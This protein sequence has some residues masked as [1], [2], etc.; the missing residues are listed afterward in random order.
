MGAAKTGTGLN[1]KDGREGRTQ[2]SINWQE[3]LGEAYSEDLEKT[4]KAEVGKN[5]VSRADF[6]EKVRKLGDHEKTIQSQTTELDNLR[7]TNV[8]AA[9]FEQQLKDKDAA[10]AAEINALKLGFAV[11]KALSDAK[12]Y[13]PA[14]VMPLLESFLQEAKIGDG[15]AVEGLAD[16]IKELADNKDTAFL[17]AKD[18]QQKLEV[19]GAEPGNPGNK[20]EGAGKA[21]KDMSYDELCAYLDQNPNANLN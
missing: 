15:G 5:F 6:N 7:K 14:T 21:P 18:T 1:K 2:M 17:F 10:H 11:E 8:D 20:G 19:A 9:A 3:I 13:N 12:A 16:K 4:I